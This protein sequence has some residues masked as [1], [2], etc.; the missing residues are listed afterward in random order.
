MQKLPRVKIFRTSEL[1][2][3]LYLGVNVNT[4][5]HKWNDL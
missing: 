1:Y 3:G 5:K 4:H 2:L